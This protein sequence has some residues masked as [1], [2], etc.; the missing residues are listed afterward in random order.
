LGNPSASVFKVEDEARRLPQNIC[1]CPKGY[2][3]SSQKRVVI[4]LTVKYC[5]C[6]VIVFVE[7]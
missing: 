5:I 4:F 6:I 7:Q 1:N 3:V 2:A